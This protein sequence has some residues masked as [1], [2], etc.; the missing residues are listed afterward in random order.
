[1]RSPSRAMACCGAPAE[2]WPSV[3]SFNS[4]RY[5]P[6]SR[7]AY[8][9]KPWFTHSGSLVPAATSSKRKTRALDANHFAPCRADVP[10]ALEAIEL[11][12]SR[13][14]DVHDDVLQVDQHPLAIALAFHAHRPEAGLLG[15][16][17]DAVRDRAHVTIGIAAGDDHRVRNVGE[18]VHVQ[19]ADVHGFHLIERALDNLHERSDPLHVRRRRCGLAGRSF[20]S[21]ALGL[22]DRGLRSC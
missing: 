15:V 22:L 12:Y 20:A 8:S 10:Q 13:Q 9:S 3:I 4:N 1:M 11:A 14:H 2:R 21:S 6:A 17:D 18:L 7:P 5:S 16:L 19:H